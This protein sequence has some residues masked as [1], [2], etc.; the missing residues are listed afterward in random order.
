MG[1]VDSPE[2]HYSGS[3]PGIA[4][5]ALFSLAAGKAYVPLGA[6]GGA[7]RDVAISLELLPSE[8]RTPRGKQD[9]SYA[10]A[11]GRARRLRHRIPEP[12]RERL[13]L[14]AASDSAEDLAQELLS[15]LREWVG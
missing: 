11:M 5:E 4:E 10:R 7:T 8:A 12:L 15:V 9:A 6:F 1:L 3:M 14:L 13:Q 2:D